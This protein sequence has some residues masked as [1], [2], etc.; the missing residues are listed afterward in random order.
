MHFTFIDSG[1]F[2]TG[3]F[4]ERDIDECDSP[5]LNNCVMGPNSE[6]V[7]T[8][9]GYFCRCSKG[10]VLEGSECVGKIQLLFCVLSN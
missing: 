2:I 9:G 8:V 1:M 3:D 6:C 7:N 10:Y 4:C 5:L